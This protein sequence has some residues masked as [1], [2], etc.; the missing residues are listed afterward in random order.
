MEEEE[1]VVD[2]LAP[3]ALRGHKHQLKFLET[4]VLFFLVEAQEDAGSQDRAEAVE[5][6]QVLIKVIHLQMTVME[7]ILHVRAVQEYL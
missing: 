4:H 7:E 2:K 5:V 3:M 6:D 1:V